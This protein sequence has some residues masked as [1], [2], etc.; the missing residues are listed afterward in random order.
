MRLGCLALRLVVVV[1][2]FTLAADRAHAQSLFE[3]PFGD[4]ADGPPSSFRSLRPVPS[5]KS[6]GRFRA[7][8]DSLR[9]D[10]GSYG[11]GSPSPVEIYR[12]V[13]VRLCDGY[14]WPVSSSAIRAK[15]YSDAEICG[16]SCDSEARLFYLPRS[17]EDV[18]GMTDLSGRA[19]G[20]LPAAFAYRTS[21]DAACTCKPMP[22]SQAD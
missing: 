17:S 19:Y 20:Q 15:F 18:G 13:C 14:Y 16:A 21:L 10:P 12:T 3:K 9:P 8:G 22:W 11:D 5:L 1:A 6:F 7:Y 4:A 2:A